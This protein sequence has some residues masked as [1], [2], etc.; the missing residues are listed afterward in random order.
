MKA[1]IM[2]G[3]E[4]T[5]LR[6]LTSLLPKP[7]VPIV[8]QPV[9]EHILGLVKHHGITDVVAT[10]AFMPQVIEEYF[11]DGEEWG[12]HLDYAV[13]ETPLGTAGSV[14]NAA[15]LLAGD[16][17][18]VV[19]SGDALTDIDLGEVIAFHR[20][21]GGAV[22]IALKAVPDPL[23]FGVVIIDD[24]GRVERFLEKPTWGQVFS[25]RINT[26]IYVVEPWVLDEIPAGPYDFSA[27][28]FPKLMEKGHAI[29]GI[30]VDGY[31]CDVGSRESYLE[32][33]RDILDGKAKIYVPGVHASESL[34]V[35]DN[36]NVASDATLGDKVVLG[37]NVTVR[38]G[39]VVG[40]YSVIGDN[41]V[42]GVDARVEQSVLW[43]E[44]F[45]G[46][47]ATVSGTVLC[48]SVDVRAGAVVD[49][50]VSIGSE[51]VVGR[52]AH[53]GANVQVYPYKRIEAAATVNSSVIWESGHS[54][55]IFADSG[56]SGLVGIDITAE[57]A[58]KIAEA[59]G[60][61][62]PKGGHVVVTRDTSRSARMIKRAMIAGLNAAGINVRDLRVASP[63]VSRFTTQK[64]RCV[65]G[66]HIAASRLDPQA[67]D[68]RFFDKHGLDIGPS[69]QKKIER[70]Y[71]RGEFRRAFFSDVGEI[72]Y[73]PRPLEYYAAA[74]NDAISD[75]GMDPIWSKVVADMG[76]GAASFVLP[77]V[78]GSWHLN[79]IALNPV[80]DSE[81]T[82]GCGEVSE[83]AVAELRRGVE[84]FGAD[85]GV[86][87]DRGA[88]R[89]RLMTGSGAVLEGERALHAV[90]DLWCRTRADVEGAIAVPL[91]AS[92]AVERLAA[93]HGRTVVRPGLSR[94]ALAQAVVDGRA[95]F[96]GGAAGGFIFGDF[97]PAFDGVLTVGMLAR[98]IKHL[99]TSLD[100]VVADL[101]DYY[102]HHAQVFCPSTRKGVVMRGVSEASADLDVD[103]TEG[104]RIRFPDGWVL[105]LPDANEPMVGVWAEG[106]NDDV[107]GERVAQWVGVVER[108]IAPD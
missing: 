44:T 42:I 58:L 37:D 59:F 41:C 38:S 92:N 24:E 57:L 53:V 84:L 40:D 105:V 20:A 3:G 107:A 43:E 5:R 33:H 52:G 54:R 23:E 2:A 79:L 45:V 102:L 17:P 85:F 95:A 9:M 72:V 46:R 48:R 4:G 66:L 28:L 90:V 69:A 12:M 96:A 70:L 35:A 80:V 1:V 63:A 7:M 60:S 101:P 31:W 87:F 106:P 71:F 15:S 88:E 14:K 99:D 16:E 36:A 89:V 13:E 67:L 75:A 78:A 27:D 56:I 50:G 108:A 94:R 93:S 19:I 39:A 51:S 62:L 76:C 100:R 21:S 73:P 29:Y 77:L 81:S 34:W 83:E 25:D 61:L 8:N 22:T 98:M 97:F 68:I 32:V 11:A 49:P 30:V 74:L 104:V 47:G 91:T 55:T 82:N 6:P 26:G 65:G 18:F 86:A 10:L 64:T 103:L